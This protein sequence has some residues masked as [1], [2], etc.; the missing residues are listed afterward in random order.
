MIKKTIYNFTN[1]IKHK[2]TA[3]GT[4][5][6]IS[7]TKVKKNIIQE[8]PKHQKANKVKMLTCLT[9]FKKKNIEKKWHLKVVT[10]V[11]LKN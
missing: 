10:P 8:V 4:V 2:S 6:Q 1:P 9:E 5:P 11:N 3:L 7:F